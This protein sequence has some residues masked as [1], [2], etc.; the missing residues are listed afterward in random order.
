MSEQSLEFQIEADIQQMIQTRY[1]VVT[2]QIEYSENKGVCYSSLTDR[3]EKT[4]LRS[5]RAK[6]HKVGVNTVRNILHSD[7]SNPYNPFDEYFNALPEWDGVTDYIK[8]LC[9]LVTVENDTYFYEWTKK[10]LVGVVA[11]MLSDDLTNHQVLVF[12]GGQGIGKTTWFESLVPKALK[13]YSNTGYMNPESKDAQIQASECFLVNMDELSSLNN[14]SIEALKQLITQKKFRV[15]RPYGLNAEN[16]VKRASFCGSTNEQE[17]LFD[18]TGNRRFL[19]F[20]VSAIDLDALKNINIDLVY[21]Q[22]FALFMN[23]YRY[24]FSTEEN[25]LIEENNE[26][27]VVQT[28]EEEAILQKLSPVSK[29][30]AT[31]LTFRW[32]PTEIAMYLF[33]N[34]L[35]TKSSVMAQ[36]VGKALKKLG[37][38]SYKT[39]GKTVYLVTSK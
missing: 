13:N 3:M 25:A 33:H 12:S 18:Y 28:A 17:F 38:Y 31:N 5:I 39:N 34:G 36:R 19:C 21:A 29:E 30:N 4:V 1:N 7:F 22:A 37:F 14:K 8:Q 10:W 9:D 20:Q 15:R 24:W 2:G 11:N 6:G 32:T 35:I 23:D 26:L 27:F 16:L